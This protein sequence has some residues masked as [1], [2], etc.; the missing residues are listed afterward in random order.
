[1]PQGRETWALLRLIVGQIFLHGSMAGMRMAAPLL[2]LREGYSA[3]SV[4]I[5][6]ALF[7]T[8]QV[9]L[10]I[11]AGR[12][13]DRHG[14]RKPMAW[15]VAAAV[16]GAGLAVVFPRFEVLCLSALLMGGATGSAIIALQRHVGRAARDA[17]ELKRVF[18]WLSIGPAVSN[19]VGPVA[20]GLLIDHAGLWIGGSAGDTWGFRAAFLLMALMPLMTWFW[21]RKTRELTPVE[22]NEATG[23]AKAWHLL[24]DPRIRRLLLVNWLL[25]SCW[26]VH[27]FVVPM[28]GHERGFSA[29]V[30]GTIL[31]CMAVA[32]AGVRV[33]MPFVAAHLREWVVVT[34]AMLVTAV[35]FAIY[36]TLHSP[37]AMGACSVVLGLSLGSV[38]PMIMST[39][40]QI[41][42]HHLHGQAIALRLMSLNFSSVV[43]PMLFGTAGAVVGVSV[44][45]WTVGAMVGLG[46]RAA[47]HMR[48]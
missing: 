3:F 45:F 39:L 6:L 26:D 32:G 38:Q 21:V 42:P 19:F 17:T 11:P 7:S 1:M 2:A 37:W 8:T 46:A 14:L 24:R 40:H 20:A 22:H 25:S 27:T 44:V 23:R 48:P 9:F 15:G 30:I 12:F 33:S 31:G 41:T 13:A 5:L 16:L 18:S 10:A 35:L 29:S 28:L 43:M 36:P 47:W 34:G 4:G